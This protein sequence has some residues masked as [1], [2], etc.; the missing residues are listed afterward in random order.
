MPPDHFAVPPAEEQLR[1]LQNVQRLLTEG[2][3]V[4]S[5]KYALLHALTDLAVLKGDETGRPLVLSLREIVERMAEIYWPQASP[6]DGSNVLCQSTANAPSLLED[7]HA[8]RLERGA[9]FSDLTGSGQP[10]GKVLSRGIRT[11][12]RE[13]VRRL[14][15]IGPEEVHFLYDRRPGGHITLRPGVAFCLRSFRGLVTDLVQSAWVRFIRR[16][17]PQLEPGPRDLHAFLFGSSRTSTAE[18]RKELL[19]LQQGRCFYCG[20][21]AGSGEVDHFVP[22]SLYPNDR[23]PNLVLADSVC[24]ANKSDMLAA[25][26]HLERWVER[27]AANRG[28]STDSRGGEGVNDP[29]GLCRGVARWAYAAAARSGAHVWIERGSTEPLGDVWRTLL[30]DSNS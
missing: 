13:P 25:E 4:S 24:N 12:G 27:L 23:R 8:V 14:Q 26:P 5:Y 22:W 3:F 17:N 16:R 19:E 2:Q 18:I 1:F 21:S 29:V 30:I 20:R 28:L 10:W 15:R 9:S 6:F 11:V 7:L